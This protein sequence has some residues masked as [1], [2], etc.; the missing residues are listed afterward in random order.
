MEAILER[1]A[2]LDVHQANVVAC[3][4]TGSLDKKPEQSVATFGTTK[5]ELIR[6]QEWLASLQITH[7]AMESTGVYW[8]PVWTTLEG[9][10]ELVLGN[11][12]LIRNVPGRKTDV[13]DAV[14]IAQLL[15][16]GLIRG[17]LIPSDLFRQLRNYS[18]YRYK[19]TG[20]ATA[21]KNRIQKIL[22]TAGIKIA[23][24]ISDVFGVSG[25]ALLQ[26][27]V[28]GEVL[29][30]DR[31]RKLVHTQLKAKVPQLVEALNGMVTTH[32]RDMI[33]MHMA[34]LQFV[35]RQIA[36]LDTRIANL[37]KPYEAEITLLKSLPGVNETAAAVILA[38]VG[39][40]MSLYPTDAHLSSWSGVCPGNNESAGKKKS[41]KTPKGKRFLK[42][43]LCQCA[44]AASFKKD[45]RIKAF[46]DRIVKRKGKKKANMAVAH[47]L[48]RLIYAILSTKQPY[49]EPGY[50]YL[51]GRQT[52]EERMIG[53]L[54][55]LGYEVTKTKTA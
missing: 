24:F 53:K 52:L 54:R 34:H 29:D 31:V 7:V 21:E 23:T 13:N 22:E 40:D 2:G 8:M 38:E 12:Q 32:H 47:L 15:R 28:D 20:Q 16:C 18:R 46:Y 14:W 41:G 26:A 6:L 19:L 10:F 9:S 27:L 3:A 36:E 25:K 51:L 37:L 43:T 4:L 17:S 48:I 30:A 49:N 50:E 35:E 55:S 45:S 33:R 11:A 5:A 39:P 1:C 44:W 42:A